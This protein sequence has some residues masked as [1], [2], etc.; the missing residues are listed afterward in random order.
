MVLKSEQTSRGLNT[1]SVT[2]PASS[3]RVTGTAGLPELRT[4]C[5]VFIQTQNCWEV[6][7]CK[8]RVF[9]VQFFLRN[10]PFFLAFGSLA[11]LSPQDGLFWS[12]RISS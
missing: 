9:E 7:A 6:K 11:T 4:Q 10:S 8:T 3:F 2:A 1:V 12:F 5:V